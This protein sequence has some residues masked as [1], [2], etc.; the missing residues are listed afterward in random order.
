MSYQPKRRWVCMDVITDRFCK[1]SE[2]YCQYDHKGQRQGQHSVA[3]G[4]K[5]IIDADSWRARSDF[6]VAPR[7]QVGESE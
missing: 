7:N 1:G 3:C 4:W 6:D 2:T 5:V